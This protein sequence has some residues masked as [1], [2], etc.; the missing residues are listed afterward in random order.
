M[1]NDKR[2]AD[3]AIGAESNGDSYRALIAGVNSVLDTLIAVWRLSL[4]ALI[5]SL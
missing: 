5:G 1:S 4:A 2:A 3:T